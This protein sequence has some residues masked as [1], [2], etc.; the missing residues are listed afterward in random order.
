MDIANI[1]R[2]GR[3][4]D[5]VIIYKINEN[6]DYI[7]EFWLDEGTE[8]FTECRGGVKI[9]VDYTYIE[10]RGDDTY[11]W[12]NAEQEWRPYK[13]TVFYGVHEKIQTFIIESV[14]LG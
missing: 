9:G 2:H 4:P 3:D 12:H 6:D 7:L 11:Y 1:K 10:V 13:K 8:C 14:L 5:I